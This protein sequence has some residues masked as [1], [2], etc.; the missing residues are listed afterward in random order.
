[1][2]LKHPDSIYVGGEWQPTDQR[3]A[4][5]NPADESLLIE[6]PVGS[7]AQVDAAIAAARHAFDDG[8][9][10]HLPV[11]ERQAVLTR[12]LGAIEARK[13]QLIDLIVA[14]AGATRML[15]EFLQ[16]GIPMKHAWR[17]VELASRSPISALPIELTPNG[18]GGTTL[19][20]GVV[21]REPVGVVAAISPYN[22][23]FFL[24]IGKVIPA[25]AV[26]CTVVLKP[27]PYTPMQAL[28]LGEIADEV[29]LPKGTFSV[30]TGDIEAGR[31][32]TSD[33]RV[34]LV[35][36][37]GSDKVGAMIQAQ[38]APNLTRVV[39]ELGG[40]SA[41]IVRSDADIQSAAAAGI[42][43]FT[44][45]CGQGCALT[46]RHIVH[47]SVRPQFVEALKAMLAQ[48]KI[49]NPA[50]PNV[51][52]G[53]LI[54]EVARKRT[55]DY[56]QI[57]RDEGATLV[58]GGHRPEGLE[59][60]FFFEPT[61][62]DNVRNDSRLAQEEVFGPIGAVIG[63]EDDDEAIAMANAS[64]FGL[65]GAIYSADPGKA[66]EM[67]LRVRTGGVSING[68]AGTMQS[69]APF[70][71]IKRSGYGREYG[72]EGLNEFTYQKTISFQAA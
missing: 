36:F 43:G 64:D 55:E 46:T 48:V 35:H 50:D 38:A 15:A 66:Y 2:Y 29:R 20:T 28:I 71:G 40:K 32:L 19:G 6:A 67:A 18:Q 70:G 44:T 24:N 63:F 13:A 60:G 16:Y 1:M 7:T 42:M 72:E 9:W 33:K 58:H 53:P 59:K 8:D 57:A 34:D 45:H 52:Y 22:F 17:T 14:E 21:S 12:F 11:R 37:T 51:S 4:V 65:S 5:I 61:L 10:P 27:S 47:N 23:P 56:V 62:F 39:M 49:G 54:R 69:D 30:V 25:L 31:L 68:G 3:E 41:L 26:G